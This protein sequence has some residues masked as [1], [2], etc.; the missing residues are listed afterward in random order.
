MSKSTKYTP[1]QRE[2]IENRIKKE[3]RKIEIGYC[4]NRTNVEG[5]YY[6]VSENHWEYKEE[7]QLVDWA[8]TN[9]N[10]DEIARHIFKNQAGSNRF[11]RD[12]RLNG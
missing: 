3:L 10:I 2:R 8:A 7:G 9:P 12:G 5:S 1:K 11:L 6:R 4:T